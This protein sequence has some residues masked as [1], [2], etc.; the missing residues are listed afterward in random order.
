MAANTLD[1]KWACVSFN[2]QCSIAWSQV[3]GFWVTF[4]KLVFDF[5]DS[6]QKIKKNEHKFEQIFNDM[7]PI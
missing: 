6:L 2:V 7:R 1:M 5:I 3:I 4:R